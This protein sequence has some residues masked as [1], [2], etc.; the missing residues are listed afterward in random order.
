MN[1]KLVGHELSIRCKSSFGIERNNR[2]Q[3]G[4][5]RCHFCLLARFGIGLNLMV[6]VDE[7]VVRPHGIFDACRDF[8]IDFK[9][10]Q[11]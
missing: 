8:D 5:M 7:G 3:H 6:G 1:Y 9:N 2:L 11:T 10:G 4:H